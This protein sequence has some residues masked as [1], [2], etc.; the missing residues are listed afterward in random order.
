MKKYQIIYADPPWKYAF[1]GTR[2]GKQDDYPTMKCD[3]ICRLG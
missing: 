3:D 2:A 1:S